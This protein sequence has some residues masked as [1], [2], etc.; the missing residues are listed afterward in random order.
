MKLNDFFD[1]LAKDSPTPGGGTVSALSGACACSLFE[2]V[3]NIT[4]KSKKYSEFHDGMKEIIPKIFESR[5]RFLKLSDEDSFAFDGFM[6]ALKMPKNTEEEKLER[7][8]AM[9]IATIKSTEVPI[10][11][12]K[13]SLNVIKNVC[14]IA[15]NGNKNALSDMAVGLMLIEVALKGAEQN[16]IINLPGIKNENKKKELEDLANKIKKEFY[17]GFNECKKYISF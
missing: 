8:K 14:Y 9:E 6:K 11:T 13:E 10:E 17:E 3:A 5:K 4:L 2:M 1:V 16:V 15:K 12:M 7:K